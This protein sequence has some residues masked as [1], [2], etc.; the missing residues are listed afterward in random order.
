MT[1]SLWQRQSPPPRVID[2]AVAII[3]AGIS[4]LSAALECEAMRL[5]CVVVE[6]D[7]P[8]ARA[9][10]RNA[11]YLMRGAAEN[12]ALAADQ[13]G[14]DR[15]RFLWKW[16]EDNLAALRALGVES[17]PG[18][19]RRASCLAA[20]AEPEASELL[21][22]ADLLRDDRFE[23]AI[24]TKGDD[25]LW[26][27]GRVRVGLLN[28]HDAVCSPVELV[29]LLR[30]SLRS[31]DILTAARV[32]AIEPGDRRVTVRARAVEITADRVLVCTNAYA[33]ELLPDL[34]ALVEP[35]RG[36][37]L[38]VRPHNPADA[39]LDCAYYLNHGSEYVRSGPDA[40]VVF[41]GA[42]KFREAEERTDRD[43]TTDAVQGELERF[44]RELITDRYDVTA[45]WS[46]I[47]G[48]SPDAMPIITPCGAGAGTDARVWFCGGLTGHGMSMGHLTARRAVR[49]MLDDAPNPFAWTPGRGRDPFVPQQEPA[50]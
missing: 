9:S 5:P 29:D 39:R 24:V 10:G 1:V 11:G 2:T 14:R 18:Y 13:L 42:R 37:M 44:V 47:M 3:G 12:Y 49:T 32:Y 8:A 40:T 31:T 4:G 30:R 26:R 23:T 28:P 35:N 36:Q 15:A 17:L 34:A 43:Q 33:R 41:G 46:G 19:A 25:A 22:S 48:F 6:Q 45:R 16:T 21:R 20:L 27:S 38:A 50:R 7:F